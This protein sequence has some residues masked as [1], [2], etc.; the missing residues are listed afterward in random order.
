MCIGKQTLSRHAS[1][2]ETGVGRI[3]AAPS[4]FLEAYRML[5]HLSDMQQVIR[6]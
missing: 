2:T 1:G 3:S 5:P 6:L 4:D